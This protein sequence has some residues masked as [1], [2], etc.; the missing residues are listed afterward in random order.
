MG[1]YAGTGKTTV[2]AL[3]RRALEQKKKSKVAF[4]SYTGKATR[5]L[6]NKLKETQSQF[7]DD[8]VGTIHS[9]IYKPVLDASGEVVGWTPTGGTICPEKCEGSI[10]LS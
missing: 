1:G 3:F 7:P 2:I 9:L 4:L 8:Y 6:A 5:V 10:R